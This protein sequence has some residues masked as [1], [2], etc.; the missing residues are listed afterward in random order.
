[1][2][3]FSFITI[4]RLFTYMIIFFLKLNKEN[5]S[6]HQRPSKKKKQK[7]KNETKKKENDIEELMAAK[8]FFT[9]S[10]PSSY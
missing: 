6:G 4:F 10:N 7:T 5:Q 1:M 8:A 2:T 9:H 3:N